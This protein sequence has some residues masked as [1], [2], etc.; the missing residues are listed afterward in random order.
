VQINSG[1]AGSAGLP[2]LAIDAAGNALG[3]WTQSD[4]TTTNAWTSLNMVASAWATPVVLSTGAQP[5]IVG[6]PQLAFDGSGNGMAVWEQGSPIGSRT[7][8][9]ARRYLAG[10]GWGAAQLIENNDAGP[11]YEPQVAMDS[12]G[13]AIAVW[14][15]YDGTNYNIYSNRFTPAGGWA[16]PLLLENTSGFAYRPK[17]GMDGNGN[18]FVVWYQANSTTLNI[19]ANRF[20][21]GGAWT[22]AQLIEN[23]TLES[24]DVALAVSPNGIAVATW[25]SVDGAAA[26]SFVWANRWQPASG[27]DG[28]QAI[29]SLGGAFDPQV[30]MDGSGNAVAVWSQNDGVRDN[31]ASNRCAIGGGWGTAALIETASGTATGARIAGS[32]SGA[33]M[34]TWGQSDGTR[35]NLLSSYYTGSGGWESAKPVELADGNVLPGGTAFASARSA[36]SFDSNGNALALWIQSDGV[37]DNLWSNRFEP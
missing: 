29:E 13:N 12:S 34:A 8:I 37:N 30:A 22:G 14:W 32:Q 31:V 25:L 3:S 9:W 18:A 1:M 24:R 15:Q 17:I 28:A 20:V 4:S 36:L 35:F 16:A 27:W 21:I 7:D 33:F 26:T 10:T 23:S 19:W 6:A 2:A 5:L 11:A